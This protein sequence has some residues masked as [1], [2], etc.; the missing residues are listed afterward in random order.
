MRISL[1]LTTFLMITLITIGL[2]GVLLTSLD[3]TLGG[4]F[5]VQENNTTYLSIDQ[6]KNVLDQQLSALDA[7]SQGLASWTPAYAYL[8][9]PAGPAPER[10]SQAALQNQRIDL[11]VALDARAQPV[12]SAALGRDELWSSLMPE[13][14]SAHLPA[15]AG[16][17]SG[18]ARRGLLA[19]GGRV[20]LL[21]ARPILPDDGSGAPRGVL[22]AGRLLDQ[23]ALAEIGALLKL[24]LNLRSAAQAKEDPRLALALAYQPTQQNPYY[25]ALRPSQVTGYAVLEDISGQPGL[26]LSV[27]RFPSAYNSG[28]LV[29]NYL[30]TAILLVTTSFAALLFL[31][32]E[33][34][35]LRPVRR[36]SGA[37]QAIGASADLAERVPVS[38]DNELAPLAVKINQMLE[39][40]QRSTRQR[41]E[42]ENRF[43]TLVESMADPVVTIARGGALRLYERVGQ[44]GPDAPGD[45]PLGQELQARLAANP[46]LLERAFG[47]Q[48]SIFEWQLGTRSFITSLSPIYDAQNQ[49][50]EVVGVSKDISAQK[51]LEQD[52]RRRIGELAA[53]FQVSQELLNRSGEPAIYQAICEL[54]CAPLGMHSA[55]IALPSADGAALQ[56][57]AAAGLD[58]AALSEI[59]L[60][61]DPANAPH[62]AAEAYNRLETRTYHPPAA[63]DAPAHSWQAAAIPLAQSGQALAVL[64]LERASP[65]WISAESLPLLHAFANLA[66]VAVQNAL[67]FEQV[68]SSRQRLQAVSRRLVEVQEEERRRIALEFHDEIGQALTGLRLSI[69][70]F[71][72]LPP[73]QV[74]AQAHAC[75]AI[76]DELIARVRQI[77]LDLR[78][79]MLDDLGLIPT[80]IWFFERYT[81]QT[82]VAVNFQHSQVLEQRFTPEVELTVFRVIQEGLTNIARYA[83]VTQAAVRVWRS[84]QVLGI[85]IEDEGAG[86]DERLAWD[87]RSSSGLAGM[88][89]RVGFLNGQLSIVTQPG[90]GACLTIEIPLSPAL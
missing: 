84:Q 3:R 68:S 56:P 80:L 51:R 74:A 25:V 19:L 6:V 11:L 32:V 17:L 89:E 4:H 63:E 12:Y 23:A 54:A 62:P 79:S 78:P 33:F 1:R 14:L 30:V 22:I 37:V 83:R 2:S 66:S 86:F 48:P 10:W 71:Q 27:E 75:L 76:A 36:L 90:E 70:R 9:N 5:G 16:P 7:A 20:Y 26:L 29:Q 28:L 42:S 55:W 72:T 49:I 31:V 8:S 15:L 24:S 87:A 73:E 61:L 46:A 52:L 47:G 60:Q 18:Q 41:R 65:P 44:P 50:G 21:A 88:R 85:Q 13:E 58:L 77:S 82:G 81:R 57:R 69:E 35:V 67:L 64:L 38:G 39:A 59:A 43:Q 45:P 34:A 40:L 53:L